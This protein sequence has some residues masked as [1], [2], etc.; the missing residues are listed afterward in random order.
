MAMAMPSRNASFI[1]YKYPG[2][3]AACADAACTGEDPPRNTT[4]THQGSGLGSTKTKTVPRHGDT[5][6]LSS[7]P[8]DCS[9]WAWGQG[10]LFLRSEHAYASCAFS[11]PQF[12]D[13][14]MVLDLPA[15]LVGTKS[16]TGG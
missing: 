15:T 2:T 9:C 6:L 1:P 4:A 10:V 13:A 7:R 12:R 8:G 14:S 11:G 5:I 16:C 3:A